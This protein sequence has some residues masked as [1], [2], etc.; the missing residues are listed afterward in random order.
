MRGALRVSAWR[1]AAPCR[2]SLRSRK[3]SSICM[4]PGIVAH[5]LFGTEIRQG[6][7]DRQHPR[8]ARPTRTR[9][10]CAAASRPAVHPTIFAPAWRPLAHHQS[11]PLRVRLAD[12][13]QPQVQQPAVLH[14][15]EGL[16]G[17]PILPAHRAHLGQTAHPADAG[18][19]QRLGTAKPRYPEAG[20][21]HHDRPAV[22]GQQPPQPCQLPARSP[23]PRRWP[24]RLALR[25]CTP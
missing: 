18:Q 19:P 22:H 16:H 20:I 8:L 15:D 6:G 4:R 21:G 17:H 2:G 12:L 7:R 3:L 1:K 14:L 9:T 24:A 10:R 25:Q 5:D 11:R 13:A 23:H